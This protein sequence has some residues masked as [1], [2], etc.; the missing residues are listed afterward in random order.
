MPDRE[1]AAEIWSNFV[2]SRRTT[3]DFLPT[4][5]PTELIDQ[6]LTDAM[7][8]PSW[9]NT[10]PYLVGVATGEVRDRISK[11]LLS[12]WAEAGKALKGGFGGS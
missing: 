8:A 1:I 10:R 7:T 6:L 12:R 4:S 11:E 9:S 3:R 2:A 5:V